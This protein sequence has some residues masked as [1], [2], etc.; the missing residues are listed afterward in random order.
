[1]KNKPLQVKLGILYSSNWIFEGS[2]DRSKRGN[3]FKTGCDGLIQLKTKIFN[4]G[5]DGLCQTKKIMSKNPNFESLLYI[6][7]RP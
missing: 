1:M 5:H 6:G 4:T 7:L 2:F 3:S